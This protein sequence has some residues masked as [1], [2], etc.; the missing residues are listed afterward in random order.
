MSVSGG[1]APPAQASGPVTVSEAPTPFGVEDY[2][3]T[4]E[5]E[6]GALDTQAGSHPFQLTTTLNMNEVVNQEGSPVPAQQFKDVHVK[7]PAGLIGNPTAVER[8]PL[9]QFLTI[10]EGS[11]LGGPVDRENDCPAGSAVGV[12]LTTIHLPGEDFGPVYTF[13]APVFNLEPEHGEP[14]RFGFLLPGVPVYIDPQVRSGT[15][16]GIDVN[17]E[18]ISQEAGTLRS[19]VTIW[20]VPGDARHNP[21][22]GNGC[23]GPLASAGSCSASA[24]EKEHPAAFLSLP[25][26][27]P[28]N[29]TTREPEP[30]QSTITVNSWEQPSTPVGPSE[31]AL[32]TALDGCNRLPFEPSISVKPDGTAGSSPSGLTVNVHVPQSETLN[33][34]GLAVADPRNITVAFPQGVAI[35]P[36]GGDGLQACSEGLVGFT[37][38]SGQLAPGSKTATFTP[39]LPGSVN[40][41]GAGETAPLEPGVNF[42]INASKIGE[43][44]IHTPVLPEPIV[45]SVYIATQNAN[46]FGSLIAVYI[47]AEDPVSGVL[48]KLAGQVHLTE[49]GQIVTTLENSPQAPFE[50][51]VFHF[52]GGER[53]PMSTPARCGTYTST[54]AF[55]S[56]AQ[57]PGE[58]PHNAENKFNITSGPNGSPCPG[59]SLP[60]APSLASSST[61]VNAG[62]F[63]NLTTTIGRADGNQD[64]QSVTLHYPPGLSGLLSGVP[65]CPEAQANAGTCPPASQIGETTVSAGVGSDPVTVT[66]GKVYITEKYHGA[67]FGLSIVNPVKAGPFD[68]EHDTSNPNQDPVCD[69]VVVRAKIEVNPHTAALTVTTNEPGEGYAIPGFIDGIPVQLQHVNVTINRPGFTFNPTNCNKLEVTGAIKGYEGASAEVKQ[70][71]SVTNCAALKFEPKI[72]VSTQGHTSRADGASLTYK[73]AYPNVPQG[74]DADIH[75]VKVALPGELPSR[76]TTLQKACTSKQ[77]DANPAGCPKESVIGHAKA[78]V[79]NI[80]VPLEGPVYFVSNGGEAFPNLVM[81]LQGY[82]VT[83]QLVGDTLIK[84]GVTSTTFNQVPDNPLTSFEINLPEG[85]YSALAANGN[86]CK[87]TVSKTVKKKVRVQVNGRMRTVTRKVKEPPVNGADDSQ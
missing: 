52:Y 19:E 37:G 53:A 67:P 20:G 15:D 87:P 10:K 18:N 69:C 2:E 27:C 8:C 64:L 70:P 48:I 45:G 82:G 60:F 11:Q 12:S 14:A 28:V 84:N 13:S 61:N 49:T 42:C 1:G 41:L 58:A 6:G 36:A 57:E 35:N 44:T 3:L 22:R 75:Y 24:E 72:S 56:W 32:M 50:D 17:V 81:V 77:F 63:S 55:T 29:P 71:F 40:A 31:P 39:R 51:A 21:S 66:G 7:W 83:I 16:Y 76:L 86:L 62:A 43:V 80:P 73:I 26:S 25:T 34:T 47:V 59:A 65:L 4:G 54:A 33:A 5:E 74:T 78:I 85:P 68:L 38:F 9:G 23:L 79:P 46:P 30:L